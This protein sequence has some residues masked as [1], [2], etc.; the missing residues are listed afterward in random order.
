MA[1]RLGKRRYG[2]TRMARRV[3]GRR[4]GPARFPRRNAQRRFTRRAGWARGRTSQSGAVARAGYNTKRLSLSRYRNALW[5]GTRF[6]THYRSLFSTADQLATPSS[7]TQVHV[8]YTSAW[9]GAA[10]TGQPSQAPFWQNSGGAIEVADDDFPDSGDIT[11]RGGRYYRRYVN[12]SSNTIRVERWEVYRKPQ[13]QTALLPPGESE[14]DATLGWD[15]TYVSK[16]QDRYRVGRK[17]VT[18]LEPGD[19]FTIENKIPVAKIDRQIWENGGQRGY[20]VLAISAGVAS[21]SLSVQYWHSCS[22][23]GDRVDSL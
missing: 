9:G 15:P 1:F 14:F 4:A 16:F 11:I 2:Y 22:F 7:A 21:Q 20:N 13:F 18:D 10:T 8:V 17:F 3:R 5:T 12:E 23:V 6:K 19:S